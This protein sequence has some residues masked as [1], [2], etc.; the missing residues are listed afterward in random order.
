MFHDTDSSFCHSLR[1]PHQGKA[2]T[3]S[4]R[5][6]SSESWMMKTLRERTALAGSHCAIKTVLAYMTS[7]TSFTTIKMGLDLD[8]GH[9]AEKEQARKCS[10]EESTESLWFSFFH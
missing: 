2:K 7:I 10:K 9:K 5:T 3:V 4:K 1:I 6:L 8:E